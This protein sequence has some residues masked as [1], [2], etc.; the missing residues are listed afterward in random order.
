LDIFHGC[1]D[2]NGLSEIDLSSLSNAVNLFADEISE[3]FKTEDEKRNKGLRL[4]NKVF[5]A[6]KHPQSSWE[7]Y[8][9]SIGAARSD[10]HRDGNH[11]TTSII[12]E[13][14]L[15]ICGISCHPH[16]QIV[17]YFAHSQSDAI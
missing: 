3:F 12:T 5:G 15:W 17:S 16:A 14:K 10:G 2:V 8:A 7:M 1:K 4:L 9:A 11:L 13:L 6:R